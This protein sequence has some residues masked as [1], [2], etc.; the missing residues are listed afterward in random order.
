[1]G[2]C[3]KHCAGYH[4]SEDAR[5][6]A[7][8]DLP[9]ML[10]FKTLARG[11]LFASLPRVHELPPFA[12]VLPLAIQMNAKEFMSFRCA[13]GSKAGKV[14]ENRESTLRACSCA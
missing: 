7:R 5:E 12:A 2:M 11:S 10:R 4:A 8:L 13:K 6:L 3:T 14:R 9:K 1:M